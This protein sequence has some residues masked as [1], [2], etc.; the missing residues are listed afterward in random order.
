LKSA[1]PQEMWGTI[2]D[3]LDQVEQ[4]PRTVARF[5]AGDR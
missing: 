4:D 2:A 1:V 5:V 3:K